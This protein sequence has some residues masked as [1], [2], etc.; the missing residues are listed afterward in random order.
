[1]LSLAPKAATIA[2]SVG[3]VGHFARAVLTD[4]PGF[5]QWVN[6]RAHMIAHLDT[7]KHLDETVERAQIVL[8]DLAAMSRYKNAPID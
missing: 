5:Q 3:E 6:A 7:L 4:L 8:Q 2:S 1:M